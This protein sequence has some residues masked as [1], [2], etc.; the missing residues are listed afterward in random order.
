MLL[1]VLAS[2]TILGSA[3]KIDQLVICVPTVWRAELLARRCRSY[4]RKGGKHIDTGHAQRPI[5][6]SLASATIGDNRG[7]VLVTVILREIRT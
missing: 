6:R 4:S 2:L 5:V 1:Q 3:L 7:L